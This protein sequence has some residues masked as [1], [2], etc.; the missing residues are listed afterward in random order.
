MCGWPGTKLHFAK[1]FFSYPFE[2]LSLLGMTFPL[3]QEEEFV[4]LNY[5][6]GFVPKIDSQGGGSCT[7]CWREV[8][9]APFEHRWWWLIQHNN[10]AAHIWAIQYVSQSILD[11]LTFM[12]FSHNNTLLNFME[13]RLMAPSAPLGSAFGGVGSNFCTKIVKILFLHEFGPKNGEK[14]FFKKIREKFRKF[15][16]F[17]FFRFFFR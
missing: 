13:T 11:N 7:V 6:F 10:M 16:F 17:R 8:L 14:K 4:R 5:G 9:Y 1:Q 12:T 15:F 3:L 2:Q